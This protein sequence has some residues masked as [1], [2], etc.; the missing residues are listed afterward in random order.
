[1][2]GQEEGPVEEEG[3]GAWSTERGGQWRV[4]KESL[5]TRWVW[6]GPTGDAWIVPES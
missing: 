5:E 1:M 6:P 3:R 4:A 2:P